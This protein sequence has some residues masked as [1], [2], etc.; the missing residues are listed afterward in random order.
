MD[1]P[2]WIDYQK[3]FDL[4]QD[5]FQDIPEKSPKQC[6]IIETRCHERLIIVIKNFMYLLQ[7]KGWGLTIFYS[8]LNA[9]FIKSGLAGWPNIRFF[10]LETTTLSSTDYSNLLCKPDIWRTLLNANCKKAL[11]FN[12]NTLLL[13]DNVDDFIEYDYI[14]APQD[15]KWSGFLTVFNGGL[16]IRDVWKAVMTT[17]QCSKTVQTQVGQR[18]LLT[19]DHYFSFH[20]ARL[21]PTAEIAA[22][23]SIE[24]I[25]YEDPCGIQRPN[26]SRFVDYNAFI[27]LFSIRHKIEIKP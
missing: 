15:A 20:L 5:Y 4:S 22:K 3:Q 25:F 27:R 1:I 6:V 17:Q 14:G 16:S 9:D 2:E 8:T 10:L 13:K 24:S 7:K 19:D 23:F 12:V 11:L 18:H 26:I 21:T